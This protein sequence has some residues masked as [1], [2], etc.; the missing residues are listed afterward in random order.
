MVAEDAALLAEQGDLAREAVG[1]LHRP[2]IIPERRIVAP[3]RVEMEDDEIADILR[4]ILHRAIIFVALDIG[5]ALVGKQGDQL[6]D[7]G[8]DK[9][10]AGRF[11]RL[12]EPARQPERDDVPVPRSE[13]HTSELQSLM[14][15]SY[16]VFCLKKKNTTLHTN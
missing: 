7:A 4:Q 5:A 14:R 13:E 9:V 15:S 2:A 11:E 6:G 8:L 3:R 1:R 16:A 12:D 10:D